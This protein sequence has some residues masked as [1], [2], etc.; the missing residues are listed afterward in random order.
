MSR[1]NYLAGVLIICNFG[2]LGRAGHDYDLI[3]SQHFDWNEPP[4]LDH[5]MNPLETSQIQADHAMVPQVNTPLALP[6]YQ[7]QH[8]QAVNPTSSS[9]GL[10]ADYALHDEPKDI[11]EAVQETRPAKGRQHVVSSPVP[12]KPFGI[13]ED[14][15]Q[16]N[17]NLE[18]S[19]IF[20]SYAALLGAHTSTQIPLYEP[21]G[22][23]R[24]PTCYYHSPYQFEETIPKNEVM[25]PTTL[26]M[27]H[28][29]NLEPLNED[30]MSSETDLGQ[31]S[32]NKRKQITWNQMEEQYSNNNHGAL[33]PYQQE[34]LSRIEKDTSRTFL[35]EPAMHHNPAI[36]QWSKNLG[37]NGV[38]NTK[39]PS[40]DTLEILPHIGLIPSSSHSIEPFHS[41]E[42]SSS[43]K[44]YNG[45]PTKTTIIL[46]RPP[47]FNNKPK[48]NPF[49]QHITKKFPFSPF[50]DQLVSRLVN[51]P[52]DCKA[53]PQSHT[54][55]E[56]VLDRSSINH[57]TRNPSTDMRSG[58]SSSHSETHH[59][60]LNFEYH[61]ESFGI[62]DPSEADE[63]AIDKILDI[64]QKGG[65]QFL[66]INESLPEGAYQTFLNV[67]LLR[68]PHEGRSATKKRRLISLQKKRDRGNIKNESYTKFWSQRKLWFRFYQAKTGINFS[69]LKFEPLP[70][71]TKE[72]VEDLFLFFMVHVDMITSIII[73]RPD[74]IHY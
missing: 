31:A 28:S 67:R 15:H 50:Q 10:M 57:L 14:P 48:K 61:V 52:P 54:G 55:S 26:Q 62:E 63:S 74:Q 7:V 19:R 6:S 51:T 40:M 30:V 21:R 12:L 16:S 58:I 71:F 70:R 66:F 17:N 59:G 1:I 29:N 27:D 45:T 36:M 47:A 32:P 65:N 8:S 34:V 60:T 53:L 72:D 41:S 56:V 39:A 11:F 9:L 42:V 44:L 18:Y 35:P 23:S 37:D 13:F 25:K 3:S 38:K 4:K 20:S 5:F 68:V 64:I 2:F 46:R 33:E 24:E 49:S 69:D 43:T 22:T 73:I